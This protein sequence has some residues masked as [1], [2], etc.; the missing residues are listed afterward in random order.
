MNQAI[1]ELITSSEGG[2]TNNYMLLINEA[3]ESV[4]NA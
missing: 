2:G 1:A 3:V 4:E